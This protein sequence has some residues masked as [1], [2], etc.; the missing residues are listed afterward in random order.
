MLTTSGGAGASAAAAGVAAASAATV[1]AAGVST[2]LKSSSGA[3]ATKQ[4]E[5]RSVARHVVWKGMDRRQAGKAPGWPICA[6][7]R[8][9]L[10]NLAT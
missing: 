5:Q 7:A 8:S 6:L 1:A 3:W 2:Y 4:A 9:V 10:F